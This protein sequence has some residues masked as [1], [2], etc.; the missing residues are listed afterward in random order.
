MAPR[1]R[2]L[3]V[4]DHPVVRQ[5][6]DLLFGHLDDLELVG[7]AETGEE[8]LEAVARLN[9]QIVL[10]DVRLPGID[11][12]SAVKRIHE[13]A[14]GVS[15][16]VFSAYG[17]KRLLSDAIAAGARGY[18]MKGSP[19]EDLIRAIRTVADGR[20]FVDPS[21][22]PMLLIKEGAPAAEQSL[23]EREREILQLLAE[24]FHTEE[25]ARRIGLSVETVKSD[26]KRVIAKLQ[27]DTR[28]HAVAIALRRALI[29]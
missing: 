26:T 18:V 6:L 24:G 15:F 25:V 21:L 3:G 19:P 1:T 16:V 5:G 7:T 17:D 20:A 2:C 27:A 12:I 28:T 4:D 13:A 23:S 29:D 11:G 22:S 9:P 10:I 8:A 14:P